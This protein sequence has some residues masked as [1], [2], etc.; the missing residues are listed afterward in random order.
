MR[1]PVDGAKKIVNLLG[2]F[3][4]IGF[5]GD[6]A[7]PRREPVVL[8]GAPGARIVI[9]GTVDTVVGFAFEDGRTR[10]RQATWARTDRIPR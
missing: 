5:E 8:N 10:L 1:Q 3:A 6:V 7:R 2:G 9:D 4:R